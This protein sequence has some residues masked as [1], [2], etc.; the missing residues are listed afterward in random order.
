MAIYFPPNSYR[1]Y[2][3]DIPFMLYIFIAFHMCWCPQALLT[4]EQA[5]RRRFF[6]FFDTPFFNHVHVWPPT[7]IDPMF[8]VYEHGPETTR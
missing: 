8:N 2:T 6:Y 4:A 1:P 3:T 5:C 7:C